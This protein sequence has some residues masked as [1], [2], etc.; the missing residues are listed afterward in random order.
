LNLASDPTIERK[1]MRMAQRV[2]WNHPAI[3]ARN[4]D[5]TRLV[6]EQPDQGDI[7]ES[8]FH[9]LVLGDSGTGRHRRHSPPRHI[10]ER[11]LPHKQTAAFLLHTGDVVYLVG[12][13]SQYTNNFIRPYREW[14]T[15]GDNWESLSPQKLLF[16]Q[17]FL[18]VLGNH[19]YYDLAPMVAALAGLT[20]PLRRHLQWFHDVDTGWRGSD[21]GGG[22]ARAF[23]DVLSDVP[24]GQLDRYL[25][26]HYTAE[27]D[28]RRCLRYRPD[29][30]TRLPNRYYRFR[31]AGVDVFALDSNTLIAPVSG[32]DDHGLLK[33]ELKSLDD[34]QIRCLKALSLQAPDE[35][36]RDGLLDELETL[37]EERLDRLR[38]LQQSTASDHEQLQW[39]RD[40]L[41]ASHRDPSARG[42]I[43]TLHHPPY[44]TEKTKWSQ[45][46]TLAIRERLRTVLDDVNRALGKQS[47]SHRT[48]DL[49]LSGHAHCLE[50]L[51]THDTGHGDSFTNWVVCGG[52][53]YSLRD[54]RGQGSDLRESSEGGAQHLIGRSEL[55]VGRS[56]GAGNGGKAYSA[57]RVDISEGRPLQILLTPL[58]SSR[59]D[60][61]WQEVAL[62]PIALTCADHQLIRSD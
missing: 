59:Q 19:D 17:P 35:S 2:R 55:Y 61:R 54:Q 30:H 28:G 56:W 15:H 52:S 18:P 20:L 46:D 22:F 38:R 1:I 51:Q 5:Q 44:V 25:D 48:V 39:L 43:L 10:A 37:Q 24:S 45:A 29:Q 57:L 13:P 47:R 12:A 4:I 7:K 62:D 3:V 41:I 50:V 53:G 16:N 33:R 36:Q 14:L 34:A 49:V 21:Q 9:F 6:I 8:G 27:W 40:G 42:R 31:H 58:I 11:L 60:Q 32:R 23:L 26:R